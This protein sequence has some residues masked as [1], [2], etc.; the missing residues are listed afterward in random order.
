MYI[1][2]YLK[3]LSAAPFLWGISSVAAVLFFVCMNQLEKMAFQ[4]IG[5]PL[6]IAS[7][8]A[9]FLPTDTVICIDRDTLSGHCYSELGTGIIILFAVSYGIAAI[10]YCIKLKIKKTRE[11]GE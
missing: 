9:A 7:V 2:E 6:L 5:I 3:I 8:V 11:F 10:A 4:L 1:F